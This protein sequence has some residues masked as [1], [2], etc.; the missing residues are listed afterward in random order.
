[1][2][3]R[4]KARELW[5]LAPFL[6]IG[7]LAFYWARIEKVEPPNAQGIYVSDFVV[8]PTSGKWQSDGFSHQVTV[9]LSYK[10]T[11]PEWWG[12]PVSLQTTIGPFATNYRAAREGKHDP[13]HTLAFG[14]TLTYQREGKSVAWA[15]EGRVYSFSGG[16]VDE[17]YV[18]VHQVSLAQAPPDLGAVGFRGLYVIGEQDPLVVT[19]PLR[20][21]G[22][23]IALPKIEGAG[24]K[25]LSVDATGFFEMEGVGA[26][27]KKQITDVCYLRFTVRDFDAPPAS[28]ELPQWGWSN[29]K[30]ADETGKPLETYTGKGLSLGWTGDAQDQKSLDGRRTGVLRVEVEQDYEL[31]GRVIC[32]GKISIGQSKPVEFKVTLPP[33]QSKPQ[34]AGSF[35]KFDIPLWRGGRAVAMEPPAK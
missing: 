30:L 7:A 29:P 1:M 21:A 24:I 31:E 5:L 13:A 10:G 11:R 6:L 8:E 33:R 35:A 18:F 14:S 17:H 26:G 28:E 34:V 25:L 27:G 15:P 9:K 19:R 4:F 20:K 23:T 16:F 32:Q 12:N 22:E 3:Q 2:R